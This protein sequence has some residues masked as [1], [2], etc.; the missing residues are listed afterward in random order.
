MPRSSSK[1]LSDFGEP[2]AKVRAAFSALI[3]KYTQI[4][5]LKQIFEIAIREPSLF[6]NIN[7]AASY[8]DYLA[9]WIRGYNE[10][11]INLPSRRKA[12]PKSACSDPAIKTIVRYITKVNA[13]TAEL[14]QSYHNLFMSAENIQGNLLEEYIWMSIAP[15]GWLWCAGNV[16]RAVDFCTPIK[17]NKTTPLQV[18]N[19]SNTEN[20]SSS[21]IRTGTDIIKWY[22][23][24]TKTRQ[25]VKM[26]DYKWEEL[27]SIVNS[28]STNSMRKCEMSEDSYQAFLAQV[29][30]KNANLITDK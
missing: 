18:K 2:E 25:G 23:L 12:E 16:L 22:R 4:S 3:A 8:S 1:T 15:F 29:A 9:R 27:N 13:E 5:D 19:K 20:S 11:L 28:H 17:D 7:N 21:A 14:Q 10:A 24:G 6:P 30:T 26:P